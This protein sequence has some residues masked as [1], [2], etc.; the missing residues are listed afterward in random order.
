VCL[1]S[2]AVERLSVESVTTAVGRAKRRQ[3]ASRDDTNAMTQKGF[4]LVELMITVAIV[5]VLATLAVPSFSGLLARRSV[6]AAMDALAADYRLARSEALKRTNFVTICRSTDGAACEASAGSWHD[7]WIVFVDADND[8][9]V[10]STELV[11]RV[12]NAVSGVSS[13]QAL[14]GAGDTR[15]ANT[16]R[17]MGISVASGESLVVTPTA[18]GGAGTRLMCISNQGRF[19]VRAEGATACN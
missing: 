8:Q 10:D 14:S 9:A 15:I 6:S 13:M 17:P 2:Q 1:L 11:L 12:Q 18:S 16:F 4:T 5:A 7:G 19:S 3:P